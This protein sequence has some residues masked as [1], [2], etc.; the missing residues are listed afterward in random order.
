MMAAKTKILVAERS[1][2]SQTVLHSMLFNWGFDVMVASNGAEACE[3]LQAEAGPRLAI[4][5]SKIPGMDAAEICRR[6]RSMSRLAYLMLLTEES[7]FEEL[8]A[9]LDAGADDYITRPVDRQE[10]RARVQ[11]GCRVVKLQERLVHAREEL[12]DQATRDGLT[13]L[14]NRVAIIQTLDSEL[15]RASRGGTALAIVMADIDHFKHVNDTYGHLAGDDVLREAAR[16]MNSILRKYDSIGRYGGEEFLIVIPGCQFDDSLAVVERL[17]EAV[18]DEPYTVF[19]ANCR[20]TASFG[21]AWNDCPDSTDANRLLRE[22]D[23]ALYSA[24][25]NGRNRVE[26]FDS[27]SAAPVS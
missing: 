13:G 23:S 21:L 6:V 24:K 22:A 18:S 19:G 9:G 26:V 1:L 17:R 2:V 3:L 7:S 8:E 14:W 15:A 4:L 10:L 27:A 12:Y 25:R 16:R 11:V 20:T 5:D